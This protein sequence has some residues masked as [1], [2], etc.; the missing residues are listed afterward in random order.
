[1]THKLDHLIAQW[2]RLGA[3]F[4]TQPADESPDLERLLLQTARLTPQSERVFVIAA[5]WLGKY[6]CLIARHRL[7]RLLVDELEPQHRPVLGLLLDT[8]REETGTAHFNGVIRSCSPAAEAG[9]LFEI[10]REDAR[11]CGLAKRHASPISR[12]WNLWARPFQAKDDALRPA[13]WIIERNAACRSRA[14][15]KGDLRASIMAALGNDPRAGESELS[16]ARSCGATR[17]A[18]RQSL[19]DLERAG[20]IVREYEGRK[21][22]S[23]LVPSAA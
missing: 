15:F 14:D 20:R 16:L 11:L 8:A 17:S 2:T 23:S 3:A 4:D 5:T 7:K 9:P 19:E 10:E 18:V 13:R 6:G 22:K 1:V 12:R 21:H